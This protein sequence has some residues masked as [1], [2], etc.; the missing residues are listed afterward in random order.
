M[1]SSRRKRKTRFFSIVSIFFIMFALVILLILFFLT[2]N[3]KGSDN[4]SHN[5][6][7][8]SASSENSDGTSSAPQNSSQSSDVPVSIDKNAWNLMV[9]NAKNP[10]PEG[11]VPNVSTLDSKYMAAGFDN[12]KFDSRAID[13]L[14]N[15]MEAAKADGV[16]LRV[17]TGYRTLSQQAT[18]FNNK[19]KSFTDQGY[20]KEEA[21][22]EAAKIVARPSTS[23]H[24][25]ALG[26]DFNSL[27]ESFENTK[28]FKWLSEHAA[29]YGFILRYPKDKQNITGVIY[30]PWH[31]R[32]V[33]VEH[34]KAIKKRG[35]CLEEYLSKD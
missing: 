11:Y 1:P 18:L 31:Y 21:V 4:S 10:M 29:D 30:E 17:R 13:Y 33:G 6:S 32:Y 9:V 35:L 24:N 3:A 12:A 26:V 14:I 7:S 23:D 22:I 8:I 34:A 19:V 16:N 2:G 5:G 20:S 27:S 25:L 28:E 15:M